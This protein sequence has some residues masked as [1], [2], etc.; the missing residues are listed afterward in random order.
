MKVHIFKDYTVLL[1]PDAVTIFDYYKVKE[2]HGLSRKGA[3]KRIDEGGL[4]I[5]GW[6]NYCPHGGKPY[7]FI[8]EQAFRG[9]HRD[10]TLLMHEFMHLSLL[11]HEWDIT[12][13]EEEIL[14]FAE[15][16]TNAFIEQ[17]L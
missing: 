17:Y 8:N 9:D 13:K 14:T 3:V 15:Q 5:E 6:A 16:S 12:N 11:L 4:Y 7:V 2:M 1:G 10:V